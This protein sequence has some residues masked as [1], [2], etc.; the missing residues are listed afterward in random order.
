MPARPR[1]LLRFMDLDGGPGRSS[2]TGMRRGGNEM[3]LIRLFTVAAA[4]VAAL[5]AAGGALGVGPW[6]GFAQSVTA[7]QSSI[8]YTASRSGETTT[9]RAL[10]AGH[11]LASAQL[12]GS[13]GIPAV[14][15]T[16]VA[17]GL[18][19][20]DRV[21]VLSEQSTAGGLRS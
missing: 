15:S 6:P 17:G 13:W 5:I 8:R 11:V 16:G 12:D 2:R 3:R 10:R 1:F 14:T 20:D 4:C 19:P 9:V 7:S 18:S 21:L